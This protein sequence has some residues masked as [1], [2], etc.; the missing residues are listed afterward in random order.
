MSNFNPNAPIVIDGVEYSPDEVYR[1]TL[2]VYGAEPTDF[3]DYRYVNIVVLHQNRKNGAGGQAPA[4]YRY[5]N[6]NDLN[7][8]HEHKYPYTLPC[9]MVTASDKK[10]NQV[11]MILFAHF[12]DVKELELVP[13]QR[14][15][16]QRPQAP[17][18]PKAE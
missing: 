4:L 7:K 5:D 6:L 11:Q 9:D 13:R 2:T 8:F 17:Q 10:G 14:Q 3:E 1:R 16:P 15:Q 12:Q 18:A